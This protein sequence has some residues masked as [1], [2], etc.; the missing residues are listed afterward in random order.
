MSVMDVF[1]LKDAVQVTPQLMPAGSDVT[2]PVP[3]TTTASV[4]RLNVADT[5][6]SA[7]MVRLQ[8]VA[9]PAEAQSPPHPLNNDVAAGVA[10]IVSA[11]PDG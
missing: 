5:V 1:L 11:V 3:A 4:G 10:T 6:L 2:E 8:V 7:L 9:L